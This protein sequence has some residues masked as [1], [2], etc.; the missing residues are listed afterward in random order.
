VPK[1]DKAR[2]AAI[3]AMIDRTIDHLLADA[4]WKPKQLIG[5]EQK[6]TAKFFDRAEPLLDADMTHDG[7]RDS[8]F[9]DAKLDDLDTPV[10]VRLIVGFTGCPEG[11]ALVR[12]RQAPFKEVKG[13]VL[14]GRPQ[15]IE[16]TTALIGG[17]GRLDELTR[18]Y[19]A[20]RSGTDWMVTGPKRLVEQTGFASYAFG[21]GFTDSEHRN[22][23]LQVA[24][25]MQFTKRYQWRVYLAHEGF[26]GVEFPTDPEGARAVFRLRDIPEGKSRRAALRHWVSEHWRGRRDGTDEVLVH[27]YLRGA[28]SF[29]WNGLICRL[30]P[31]PFDI[32]RALRAKAS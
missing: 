31:S 25:G 9:S 23:C 30:T 27:E 18:F 4:K 26:P 5:P 21:D 2:A 12:Y 22:L 24:L 10:D 13:L 16:M 32:E 6:V 1:V 7:D 20:P 14:P 15:H 8:L 3:E 29:T 28:T 19:Y 17:G 11:Y